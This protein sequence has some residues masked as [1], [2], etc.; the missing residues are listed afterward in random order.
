MNEEQFKKHFTAAV[1]QK[2]TEKIIPYLANAAKL[3]TTIREA[4]LACTHNS[5]AHQE[6]ADNLFDATAI[7]LDAVQVLEDFLLGGEKCC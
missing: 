5:P 2:T 1:E 3:L 7:T 6:A 4:L